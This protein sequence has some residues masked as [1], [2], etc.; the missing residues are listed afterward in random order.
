MFGENITVRTTLVNWGS[1]RHIIIEDWLHIWS[2][3]IDEIMGIAILVSMLQWKAEYSTN[4]GRRKF[5]HRRRKEATIKAKGSFHKK[6]FHAIL[7][8]QRSTFPN[9]LSLYLTFCHRAPTTS[10]WKINILLNSTT[11]VSRPRSLG[12]VRRLEQQSVKFLATILFASTSTSSQ[13]WISPGVS[14]DALMCQ[15]SCSGIRHLHQGSYSCR[16]PDHRGML[17]SIGGP[18]RRRFRQCRW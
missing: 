7:P 9:L 8:A 12:P 5:V 4:E 1:S 6:D 11:L 15:V 17:A 3:V 16:G 13:R 2:E 14:W 10:R 18:R